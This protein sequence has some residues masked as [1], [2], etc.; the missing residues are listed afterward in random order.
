MF[1]SI[2]KAA[3]ISSGIHFVSSA[4]SA[5]QFFGPP[6]FWSSQMSGPP[7]TL[8]ALLDFKD[9]PPPTLST[10]IKKCL[11]RTRTD[12]P[13]NISSKKAFFQIGVEE[14]KAS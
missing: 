1:Y 14:G 7:G 6:A 2:N 9:R 12:V 4:S 3:S 8:L 10:D 13:C 5:I 11:E